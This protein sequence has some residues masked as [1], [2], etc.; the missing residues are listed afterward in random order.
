[1]M[2]LIAYYCAVIVHCDHLAK[3][4]CLHMMYLHSSSVAWSTLSTPS[5]FVG[6]KAI[7]W[8]KVCHNQLKNSNWIW[9]EQLQLCGFEG[10]GKNLRDW[11]ALCGELD[12]LSFWDKKRDSTKESHHQPAPTSL[13]PS[14]FE[15]CPFSFPLVSTRDLLRCLGVSDN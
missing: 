13:H 3:L 15:S 5:L 1:M 10:N 2:Y 9:S 8:V 6:N 11:D 12:R 4:S 14:S 7:F